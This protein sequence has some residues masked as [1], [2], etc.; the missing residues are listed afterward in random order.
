[1]QRIRGVC[2]SIATTFVWACGDDTRDG[3][4]AGAAA[5]GGTGGGQAGAAAGGDGGLGGSEAGA[6]GI[7][8]GGLAGHGAAAGTSG[9]A[10]AAGSAGSGGAAACPTPTLTAL[11]KP[12]G[13]LDWH[14]SGNQLVFDRRNPAT[15]CYDV[16]TMQADG[17]D[18]QCLSCQNNL[19]PP[20][21]KGQPAWHPNGRH[22]IVQAE[23]A[24][25]PPGLPCGIAANPGAGVYNDIWVLDTQ[26]G[27]AAALYTVANGQDYGVLH[28]HVSPDGSKLLWSELYQRSSFLVPGLEAGK[29]NLM[30]ADLSIAGDGTMTL[31]NAKKLLPADGTGE[32]FLE[33]HGFTPSG[34]RLQFSGNLGYSVKLGERLDVFFSDLNGSN[35]QQLTNVAYN[36]HLFASKSEK[37]AVFMS[38]RWS[39]ASGSSEFTMVDADGQNPCRLSHFNEPGHPESQAKATTAADLAWHPDGSK[40]A[41]YS[42]QTGGDETIW[43]VDFGAPQ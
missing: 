10:G 23:K 15:N 39:T 19:L 6:G 29:W 28:P 43:L 35:R 37:R 36:E 17:S 31:A 5:T 22:L 12:G 20:N 38:S 33:S 1:M 16:Y 21:N 32:G 27:T 8:T 24:V 41:G 9:A 14:P 18:I 30:I 11:L 7:G 2:V 3:A 42:H 25:H 13:R 4:A 40:F 34:T 26:T